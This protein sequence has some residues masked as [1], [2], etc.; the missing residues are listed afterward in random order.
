MKVTIILTNDFNVV[1]IRQDL[2]QQHKIE[3]KK[4]WVANLGNLCTS[5]CQPLECSFKGWEVL[6]TED[7]TMKWQKFGKYS[8]GTNFSSAREYIRGLNYLCAT[9]AVTIS[10]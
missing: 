7:L 6:V 10:V 4:T 1:E 5:T 9:V 2:K 8:V 3:L